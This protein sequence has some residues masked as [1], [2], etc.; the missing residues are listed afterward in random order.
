VCTGAGIL[1]AAGLLDGHR[2]A[3]HW[4]HAAYLAARFPSVQFDPQP[5]FIEDDRVCTSAGVTAALDLML[6]FI[7][8]DV[9]ADLARDVARHLVTYLQRPG[10]QAQMSM[11]TAAPPP[12]CSLLRDTVDHIEAHLGADLT[13]GCLA[14]RVGVSERHLSRLFR[15]EL[16]TSPARFVRRVRAEAAAH[17]LTGTDLTVEAIATRC[18]YGTVETLRQAF[19]RIYGVSPSQYR[20]TQS[21]PA[22]LTHRHQAPDGHALPDSP[23]ARTPDR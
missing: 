7:E 3:T 6:S 9:G 23:A 14:K 18:G 19:Q 13:A 4:Y 1:A 17:L 8:Q 10:N 12:H 11:F 2:A 22:P 5:I 16:S 21:R 20:A 15:K